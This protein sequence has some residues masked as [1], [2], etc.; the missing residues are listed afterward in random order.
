MSTALPPEPAIHEA[1]V[2]AGALLI[3]R[4]GTPGEQTIPFLG[5]FFVGRECL[6]INEGQRF[7]IDDESHRVSRI[8]F[9]VHLEPALGRAVIVDRSTNGTWLNKSRIE[10]FQ[11]IPL[12]SG[13]R[14]TIT[15]EIEFEF[16][17]DGLGHA[18]GA[19]PSDTVA[20]VVQSR[21]ALV[22]GDIVSYAGI[23][24]TADANVLFADLNVLYAELRS[25]MTTYR[26]TFKDYVGDA[27][28][29]YWDTDRDPGALGYA[30]DFCLAATHRVDELAPQLAI[31]MPDGAPLRMG[32]GVHV[33]KV[34]VSAMQGAVLAVVGDATNLAFRISG[35]S[36]RDGRPPIVVTGAVR[37]L[38]DER[39]HVTEEERITVKSRVGEER[40]YGILSRQP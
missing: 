1:A 6:G 5:S 39:Y 24:E 37:D 22:V 15:Q 18:G 8:H 26:G 2:P 21:L 28:F 38:L 7:L 19:S 4:P 30:V 10:R 14:I 27:M 16:R 9:E 3:L 23:S 11:Q 33:G 17:G 20:E 29:G 32:W 13:D 35:L 31:R 40:L 34:A 36:N 25:L 12:K